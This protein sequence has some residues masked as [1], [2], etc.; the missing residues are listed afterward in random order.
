MSTFL[1]DVVGQVS[2]HVSPPG[3]CPVLFPPVGGEISWP[4]PAK[5][6]SDILPDPGRPADTEE[7]E[8]VPADLLVVPDQVVVVDA[9]EVLVVQQASTVET[10]QCGEVVLEMVAND[11]AVVTAQVLFPVPRQPPH[12]GD[13]GPGVPGQVDQPQVV[14]A[15]TR[16]EAGKVPGS[17]PDGLGSHLD[18]HFKYY[19]LFASS[20]IPCQQSS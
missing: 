9:K 16:Q 13:D 3:V 2:V 11:G 20:P 1:R 12:G 6:L 14:A 15:T 18:Y 19:F 4:V 8:D 5:V 17:Q 7:L 10:S